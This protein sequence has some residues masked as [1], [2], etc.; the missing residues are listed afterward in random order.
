[1]TVRRINGFFYGLFMDRDILREHTVSVE[2]P[3]RAY[4][5]HYALR[6]GQRATLTPMT[7]ARAYGM[8]FSL[9]FDDVEKLYAGAGLEAYCPEAVLATLL[10]GG[11]LPAICYNLHE[12]PPLDEANPE[13][14][15]NLRAALTRL[16]FP[17]AYVSGV[18]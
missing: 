15:G 7:E 4:V 1:M 10:E 3:R 2:N 17:A 18:S 5:D 9:T 12:A 16:G 8:V 11:V 6:I 14:A 13:Y